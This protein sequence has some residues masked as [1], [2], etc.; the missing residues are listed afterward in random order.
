MSRYRYHMLIPKLHMIPGAGKS[1]GFDSLVCPYYS[2][3]QG[4]T[5]SGV[6]TY[7][8]HELTSGISRHGRGVFKRFRKQRRVTKEIPGSTFRLKRFLID[9]APLKSSKFQSFVL[10]SF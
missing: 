4:T 5:N 3:K 2:T 9:G 7:S 6:F 1:R 8:L 10:Q